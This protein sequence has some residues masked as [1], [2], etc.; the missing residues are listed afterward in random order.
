[1]YIKTKKVKDTKTIEDQIYNYDEKMLEYFKLINDI[2]DDKTFNE[3]IRR[4]PEEVLEDL[5]KYSSI[6]RI[7]KKTV[8][9]PRP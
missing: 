4:Y 9:Y 7:E 5:N 2:Q 1:M 8:N 6:A 3:M